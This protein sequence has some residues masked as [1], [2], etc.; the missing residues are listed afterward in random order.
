MLFGAIK[1]HR[2]NIKGGF[3]KQVRGKTALF[4]AFIGLFVGRSAALYH[5]APQARGSSMIKCRVIAFCP[6]MGL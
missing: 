4:T 5:R 6:K 3:C 1:A 2:K